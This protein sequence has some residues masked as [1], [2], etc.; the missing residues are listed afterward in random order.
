MTHTPG[1]WRVEPSANMLGDIDV[2]LGDDFRI[3]IP[4]RANDRDDAWR[5]RMKSHA[6]LIASAPAMLDAL[7][8]T[9]AAL[10]S[11]T[12]TLPNLPGETAELIREIESHARAAIDA[13]QPVKE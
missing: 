2:H 1:N 12:A 4:L 10:Q 11:I 6:A 9:A 7:A 8:L 13:A 3:Y 5:T